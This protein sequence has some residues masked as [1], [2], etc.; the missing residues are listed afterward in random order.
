[1]TVTGTVQRPA[2]SRSAGPSPRSVRTAGWMPR[3]RSRSSPIARCASCARLADEVERVVAAL[4]PLGRDPQVQRTRDEPLLRA[5][6]QI[7]L[8]A[9]ALR[10]GG[11]DDPRLRRAQVHDTG[12][13]LG[14]A[15]GGQQR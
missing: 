8:Q 11:S 7:A 13:E 4:E 14:L 10:V 5:V 15:A 6:V 12:V 9:A 1:M 3:A 2:T